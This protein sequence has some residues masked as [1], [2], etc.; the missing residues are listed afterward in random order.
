MQEVGILSMQRIF[1]YGSFLQAYGLKKM[2]EELE[3]KVYFVDYHPGNCLISPSEGT[4]LR[5]K[6]KKGMDA[7][8]GSAPISEKLKYIKYKRT[9]AANYY[10]YLEINEQMNYKTNYDLLIIG[11]DEV[12]NCVQDNVNVGFTLELFGAGNKANR[13]ISYAAS[14]G[15]TT[16][17]KLEM[18][19]ISEQIGQ[20]LKQFDSI[21]VR[22]KNSGTIVETLTD[23]RPLYHLDPVL[24]Y[25]FIGKCSEIPSSV[26]Y[27]NY[28]VLYG[29][30]N[31]FCKDECKAI[32]EFAHE[33]NLRVFC[34]GGIQDVCDLF[35]DCNPF[36]VIAYFKNAS[37]VF[38]DTFHGA[39]LSII[40]N[41]TFVSLV[42]KKGYGN[43]EKML[44]LLSRLKLG[45]RVADD[46]LQN[47]R[48]L[49]ETP[50][51]Y[52][53]VNQLIALERKRSYEYLKSQLNSR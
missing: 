51:N 38:T 4:G 35:I 1:N 44:D 27:H 46:N 47:L 5:R 3:C 45:G 2:L 36:E 13:L 25:D 21:S 34:I 6:L 24:A 16:I 43:S 39:I 30:S 9:Y 14:F 22:D 33:E 50:I 32:K 49:C 11:S 20:Q 18:H 12:F 26:P 53:A 15:N 48:Q 52:D 10:P 37:Y 8:K 31:R 17:E 40:A 19:G 41:K 23:I 7:L 28:I 42:R 29:Y